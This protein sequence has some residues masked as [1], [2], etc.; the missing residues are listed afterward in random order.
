MTIPAEANEELKTCWHCGHALSSGDLPDRCLECGHVA[1]HDEQSQRGLVSIAGALILVLATPL[2]FVV[3]KPLESILLLQGFAPAWQTFLPIPLAAVL[4]LL[5]SGFVPHRRWLIRLSVGALVLMMLRVAAS[6]TGFDV[7]NPATIV[8]QDLIWNV[9]EW[10]SRL[11]LWAVLMT[12]W[13]VMRYNLRKG[14]FASEAPPWWVG[15]AAG[16]FLGVFLVGGYP[17]WS[18]LNAFGYSFYP[19]TPQGAASP[20]IP[21][22][23]AVFAMYDAAGRVV[24]SMWLIGLCLSSIL[25]SAHQMAW[26]RRH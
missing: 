6:A 13:Y 11:G 19:A 9:I 3:A 2:I 4:L 24:L 5:G 25:L 20:P 23:L 10:T 7:P 16:V 26:L 22:A 8:R 17:L 12:C 18:R 1:S 15:T 14:S 21:N